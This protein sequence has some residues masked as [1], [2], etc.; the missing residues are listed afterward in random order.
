MK[1][2][3]GLGNPGEKYK[4]TRHNVGFLFV[5]RLRKKWDFPSFESLPRF[6]ALVATGTMSDEKILLVKP[7]TYMNRSGKSVVSLL[8]FYKLSPSDLMVVHDDLDIE[9]GKCK[10]TPSASSA[11]HNGVS[12]IIE[13]LGTQEFFRL[14]IGIGRSEDK[15]PPH[16]YV[17]QSFHDEEFSLLA[18]KT[19][20]EAEA[21]L[22]EWLKVSKI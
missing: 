5:E 8:S 21:K 17:L 2:I 15:T 18:E 9:K 19:F 16:D 12:D 14:R 11:G 22:T 1:L 7:E 10:G 6:E 4:D 20:P 13:R 3:V